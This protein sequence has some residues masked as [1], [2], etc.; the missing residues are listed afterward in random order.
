MSITDQ[1]KIQFYISHA[2]PNQMCVERKLITEQPFGIVNLKARNYAYQRLGA[3]SPAFAIWN[4]LSGDR[5]GYF[6]AL[7]KEHLCRVLGLSDSSYKRGK[8]KL[9]EC[10]FL[11]NESPQGKN[12]GWVFRS[13]PQGITLDNIEEETKKLM[14][15]N[16]LL[17]EKGLK[18]SIRPLSNSANVLEEA[19]EEKVGSK[20][21]DG[22]FS[23]TI[24][25]V[26]SDPLLGSKRTEKYYTSTSRT[27][28]TCI[29]SLNDKENEIEENDEKPSIIEADGNTIGS[30]ESDSKENVTPS[31]EDWWESQET[32]SNERLAANRMEIDIDASLGDENE[33][34]WTSEPIDWDKEFEFYGGTKEYVYLYPAREENDDRAYYLKS[35]PAD[36]IVSS[37]DLARMLETPGRNRPL[38]RELLKKNLIRMEDRRMVRDV[39]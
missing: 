5:D 33:V 12:W 1:E 11:T 24:G 15:A 8:R 7:S 6:S 10:G 36:Q 29:H 35:F 38:L 37:E 27:T 22:G 18:D 2:V 13:L 28:S 9:Q 23:K 14:A 30:P 31:V 26:L 17:E 4:F 34:H 39:I 3:L 25:Q 20:R 16:G 21:T 32:P 19:L